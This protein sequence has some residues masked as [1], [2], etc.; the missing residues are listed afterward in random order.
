VRTKAEIKASN[1]YNKEKTISVQLRLNRST[2]ADIISKLQ[3]VPSK[4]G[5][6]KDL[7]RKDIQCAKEP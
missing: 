2:D 6:I 1:K 5:Y 7:I 4:M 3:S